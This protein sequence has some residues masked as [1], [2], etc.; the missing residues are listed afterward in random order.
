MGKFKNFWT[1]RKH[2]SLHIFCVEMAALVSMFS[3]DVAAIGYK[4]HS[5]KEAMFA[6]TVLYTSSFKTSLSATSGSVENIFVSEDD[7]QCFVL[8]KFDN[9]SAISTDAGKYFMQMTNC[10]NDG[11]SKGIPNE[12]VKGRFYMFGATGYAGLYLYTTNAPFTNDLKQIRIMAPPVTNRSQTTEY[13]SDFDNFVLYINPSGNDGVTASF[14]ENHAIGDAFDMSVMY[15]RLIYYPKEQDIK[16]QLSDCVK[17]MKNKYDAIVEYRNRLVKYQLAVP[18]VSEYITGDVISTEYDYEYVYEYTTDENGNSVPKIDEKT[19]NPVVLLDENGN[20][21][22]KT[23]ENGNA[24]YG[25]SYWDFKANTVL[26]GGTM[27]DY[28]NMSL[29]HGGYSSAVPEIMNDGLS[30]AEYTDS[31]NQIKNANYDMVMK[32][33]DVASWSYED[34]KPFIYD[35]SSTLAQTTQADI[36]SYISISKAYLEL[37]YNY[38]NKLLPSLLTLEKDYT[39]MADVYT[40]TM[41]EA[42]VEFTSVNELGN[43]VIEIQTLYV[44]DGVLE[45][46]GNK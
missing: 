20:P 21:V 16:K 15:E 33:V 39:L 32:S 13:I 1:N 29:Q 44:D 12:G 10:N 46:W 7:R 17:D 26:P 25:D 37:K 31:L 40:D 24:L 45:L 8:L 36:D 41:H 22:I 5:D 23:D 6:D 18:D 14:M 19:G 30:I 28:H 34:G 35:A 43:P 3:I 4:Y 11:T 27:F 38:Q 2:Y 42:E 9:T